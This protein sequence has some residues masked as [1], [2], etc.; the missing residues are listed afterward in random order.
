MAPASLLICF[1]FATLHIVLSQRCLTSPSELQWEENDGDFYGTITLDA[2]T[3]TIND[4]T[5]TTRTINQQIPA[6]TMRMVPGNRYF[7]KIVN[8]LGPEREGTINTIK[9]LNYTTIHTHGL[10]ISGEEPA[11]SVWTVVDPGRSITAIYE[12]PCFHSGGTFWSVLH[13]Y[14]KFL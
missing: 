6:P 13:F 5:F 10:H 11:D 2:A 8:N 3:F 1:I 14:V 7:I 9:D 4:V 12:P